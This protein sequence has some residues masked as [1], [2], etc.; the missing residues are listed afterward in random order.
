MSHVL[1]CTLL[2][3]AGCVPIPIPIPMPAPDRPRTIDPPAISAL[4]SELHE[5]VNQYR[6]S[7]NLPPLRWDGFLASLAREHSQRVAERQRPFGHADFEERA[8]AA[9]DALGV[10]G[11]S[12]NVAT[13]NYA[14]DRVVEAVVAGWIGSPGHQQ[15]LAGGYD[16]SGVGIARGADGAYFI[17]QIYAAS[18]N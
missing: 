18:G 13:N 4:E 10:R 5:R 16:L 1:A 2:V 15:N 6:T 9:Q 17:T 3:F 7:R 11:M 14:P 8:Q 12:E